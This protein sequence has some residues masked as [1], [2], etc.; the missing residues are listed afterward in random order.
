M[1]D[2]SRE[3]AEFS[4]VSMSRR[5][6]LV[7][8]GAAAL[9]GAVPNAGAQAMTKISIGFQPLVTGPLWVA[10]GEG[11]F[12]KVGL[13]VEWIRFTSAVAQVTALQGGQIQIGQG[14]PGP[15]LVG[16]INGAD[17]SWF[18]IFFDYN[19]LEALV[20]RPNLAA[21]K[22][23]DLKGKKIAARVGTDG[24]F[25]ILKA[26]AMN[27]MSIKDVEF[28]NLELPSQVAALKAGDIDAAYTW[29]PFLSQML[30]F[31]GRIILRNKE[32][33]LGPALAGWAAKSEWL[34]NNRA[35]ALKALTAVDMG[36]RTLLQRP[37]LV[38]KYT[39]QFTGITPADAERQAKAV[40]YYPPT[41]MADPGSPLVWAKGSVLS[42]MVNEWM[43]FAVDNQLIKQK[44][45][46]DAYMK[47]GLEV[48]A[49]LL[50]KR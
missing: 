4:P 9:A 19:P 45:D 43:Q 44:G 40:G 48:Q 27:G 23:Q 29:D 6:L 21:E 35:T 15:F 47:L 25:L 34:R 36:Y 8:A 17:L 24:Q 39:T 41:V 33:G 32:L 16:S 26:L 1:T 3:D 49:E 50:K 2:S 22:I 12:E 28:I 30:S 5:R 37:E 11:Y 14:A 7:G 13:D 10:R 42:N 18:S 20:I 38:A 46:P 31:G